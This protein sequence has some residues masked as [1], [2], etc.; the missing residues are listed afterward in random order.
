[1]IEYYRLY[2][3]CFQ[4]HKKSF[5]VPEYAKLPTRFNIIVRDKRRVGNLCEGLA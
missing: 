4:W 3:F 2:K 5:N 1:M